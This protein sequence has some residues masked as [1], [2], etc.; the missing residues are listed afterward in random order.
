MFQNPSN[1]VQHAQ[2]QQ[3]KTSVTEKLPIPV[4]DPGE[5]DWSSLVDTATRAMLSENEKNSEGLTNWTEGEQMNNLSLDSK[6]FLFSISFFLI[7]LLLFF[8]EMKK[9]FFF[10]L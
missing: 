6:Y 1:R 10:F 9:I 5:M 2:K 8:C 4:P 7:L 3:L